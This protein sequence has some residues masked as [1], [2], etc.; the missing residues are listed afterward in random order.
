[1]S[2]SHPV[3][4][5]AQR[6]AE[7]RD[8]Q[9]NEIYHPAQRPGYAC[10][11]SLWHDL[12]GDLYV[13]FAEKRGAPNTLWEPVPLDFWESMGLPIKYHTSF[14]NGSRDVLT[15]LVV[16]KSQDDGATWSESGRSPSKVINAF[17]WAA[18]PGGRIIRAVSDDYVAFDPARQPQLRTE[19]SDDGGTTWRVQAVILEGFQ[20]YTYCLNRLQD[21]SLV[22][23]APYQEAFG[24][25]RA[26]MARHT[27]RPNAHRELEYTTGVFFSSDEGRSWTGPQTAFPGD[28]VSEPDVV[29]LPCGDLIFVY[30]QT[31]AP[32]RVQLRQKFFRAAHGFVPGPVFRIESGDAPERMVRTRD[33]LLVGAMRGGKYSC[34]RDEGATWYDIHGLP[35]CHYQPRIIELSDGRLL[36]TWHIGGDNFF[37]EL[38]QWVGSHLFRLES[39]LPEPTRLA[40]ARLLDAAGTKYSNVYE[41]TLTQGG[42]PLAGRTVQFAYHRMPTTDYKSS[43]DPRRAGERRTALTDGDGRARLDLS[44]Y[45]RPPEGPVKSIFDT[46]QM[47]MH[48]RVT[49]WFEPG[50]DDSSLPSCRSDV[51]CAYPLTMSKQELGHDDVG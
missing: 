11:T 23:V 9:V 38:D 19:V 39:D 40:L 1:M 41:V 44:E 5:S 47:H 20:C 26:R 45:E 46:G 42:R 29:E 31:G 51:Y 13:A 21:G 15:E 43:Y 34:S 24:P 50:A 27:I 33:G 18:L 22:L 4:H 30:S 17:A 3:P 7:A 49:A 25:G 28:L 2:T 36:T 37:G 35:D 10:W 8:V 12:N 32:P 16:L 48:Y 6:F 14:C